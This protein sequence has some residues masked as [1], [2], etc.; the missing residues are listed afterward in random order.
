MLSTL[1][2]NKGGKTLRWYLVVSRRLA[3]NRHIAAGPL[4]VFRYSPRCLRL[5][6]VLYSLNPAHERSEVPVADKIQGHAE[7]QEDG[8]DQQAAREQ[9]VSNSHGVLSLHRKLRKQ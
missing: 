5:Q 3:V 4:T 8:P 1:P 6:P 9:K 2:T 7:P